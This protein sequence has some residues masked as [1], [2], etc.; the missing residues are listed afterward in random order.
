VNAKINEE[1]LYIAQRNYKHIKGAYGKLPLGDVYTCH[2]VLSRTC[3]F[4]KTNCRTF[5]HKF[6]VG[7]VD[8]KLGF[9]GEPPI[10]RI[11]ETQ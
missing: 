3:K 1:S 11:Y 4:K 5:F 8:G 9:H 2:G 6:I 10:N 7:F